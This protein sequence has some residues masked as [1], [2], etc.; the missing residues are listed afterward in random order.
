MVYIIRY[1]MLT[2]SWSREV[3]T[4]E[5]AAI[6]YHE[7]RSAGAG[8]VVVTDKAGRVLAIDDLMQ[9]P[10]QTERRQKPAG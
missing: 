5:A 7:L 8:K 6:Q 3:A 9:L 2:G 10:P 4:A 1:T